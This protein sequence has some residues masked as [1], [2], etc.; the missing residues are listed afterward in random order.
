MVYSSPSPR[1]SITSLPAS[2]HASPRH[3]SRGRQ[4][5]FSF[6]NGPSEQSNNV[7]DF[8]SQPYMPSARFKKHFGV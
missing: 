7:F 6:G 4:R 8:K 5:K 3:A 2:T 1:G